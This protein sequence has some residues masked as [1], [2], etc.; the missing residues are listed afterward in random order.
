MVEFMVFLVLKYL[1]IFGLIACSFGGCGRESDSSDSSK[2]QSNAPHRQSPGSPQL[3]SRIPRP[4]STVMKILADAEALNGKGENTELWGNLLEDSKNFAT[5][6]AKAQ[7]LINTPYQGSYFANI[8]FNNFVKI[9]GKNQ[10]I[11]S[12]AVS[13]PLLAEI[14]RLLELV[15]PSTANT[16]LNRVVD[17]NSVISA[18]LSGGHSFTEFLDYASKYQLD[19]ASLSHQQLGHYFTIFHESPER[20]IFVDKALVGTNKINDF[21][22]WS[23]A[24]PVGLAPGG[25]INYLY[26]NLS[27]ARK[28]DIRKTWFQEAI[29]LAKV[30][31]LASRADGSEVANLAPVKLL[32]SFNSILNEVKLADMVSNDA[33]RDVNLL[34]FTVDL[35]KGPLFADPRIKALVSKFI[36]TFKWGLT[37]ADYQVLA[38]DALAIAAGAQGL[39]NQA[40]ARALLEWDATGMNF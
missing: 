32:N 17:G 9:M 4:P 5:N 3:P 18:A 21:V 2:E 22:L 19:F 13:Q 6:A 15:S 35:L 1:F 24:S 23:V 25:G 34:T 26:K 40:A 20:I 12:R 8:I 33:N 30:S 29:R 36:T 10:V 39:N 37:K 16:I 7:E 11:L 27:A 31:A 14:K 38:A 28:K